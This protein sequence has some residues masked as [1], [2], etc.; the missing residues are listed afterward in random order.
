MTRRNAN[1]TEASIL[2]R[3]GLND[4]AVQNAPDDFDG[5]DDDQQG[6][7]DDGSQTQQ[8]EADDDSSQEP[9]SR[10]GRQQDEVEDDGFQTV[11]FRARA[12]K[13]SDDQSTQG[14]GQRGKQQQQAPVI[15]PKTGK[16]VK[17]QQQQQQP[18]QLPQQFADPL[19]H[20]GR[21]KT[22][23]KGNI[24]NEQGAIIARAGNERRLFEKARALDSR[25]QVAS[26][27]VETHRSQVEKLTHQLADTKLLNGQPAAMGLSM[28][29]AYTGLRLVQMYKGDPGQFFKYVV[30]QMT[31]A[32][33][34]VA[35]FGQAAGAA[36]N[37]SPEAVQALIRQTIASELGPLKQNTQQQQQDRAADDA[38]MKEA[39]EFF[40]NFP[41]AQIHE[42]VLAR[43]IESDPRLSPEAA[44]WKLKSICAEQDFDFSQPLRPQFEARS[45]QGSQQQQRQQQ[46]PRTQQRRPMPNGRGADGA[47]RERKESLAAPDENWDVIIRQ[48]MQENG[49]G[50]R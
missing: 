20:R 35:K 28:E 19:E 49:F 3:V 18:Q 13:N 24:L 44:Y 36:V 26:R 37:P 16:P 29:E 31:K 15:D 10:R 21:Y 5:D 23:Q 11:S 32:G 33:H 2:E 14:T 43:L 30:D 27:E 9:Q 40:D 6:D 4:P 42:D 41:D 47:V 50:Q 45:A 25:L 17:G 12:R 8:N 34:D 39:L 46:Q 7:D 48:S 38:A 1:S 22:D